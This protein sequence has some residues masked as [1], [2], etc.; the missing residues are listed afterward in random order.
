VSPFLSVV[1]PACDEEA[2]LDRALR[3]AAATA[4]PSSYDMPRTLAAMARLG[5]RLHLQRPP[6]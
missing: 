5:A 6:S 3:A 1:L 2:H 4:T